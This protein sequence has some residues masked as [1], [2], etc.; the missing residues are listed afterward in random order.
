MFKNI[1]AIS[2][3]LFTFANLCWAKPTL[4]VVDV[5]TAKE[6][7]SFKID[8]LESGL[9]EN[10]FQETKCT[11][12]S[13]ERI[14]FDFENKV[15][16][17]VPESRGKVYKYEMKKD[18]VRTVFASTYPF[19]DRG[20]FEQ[21][22]WID[23][24]SGHLRIALL[25][26]LEV[27][28]GKVHT[29]WVQKYFPTAFKTWQKKYP[30]GKG[31]PAVAVVAELEADGKWKEIIAKQ[32]TIA[33]ETSDGFSVVKEEMNERP[34]TF[35]IQNYLRSLTCEDSQCSDL[36]RKPKLS[37][38]ASSWAKET[39]KEDTMMSI[40]PYNYFPLSGADG[41]LA[42][43]EFGD[44]S[45]WVSPIFYCKGQAGNICEIHEATAKS[46]QSTILISAQS[47]YLLVSAEYESTSALLFK[48]GS[49]VPIKKFSP[50]S[51][52]MWLP[53]WP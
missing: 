11:S 30:G 35:S 41:I 26:N 20:P 39:F 47:P 13:T 45:H 12:P 43:V 15:A 53:E 16:F 21:K 22:D 27:N 42:G 5:D 29:E 51:M 3:A 2:F 31:D 24:K 48:S 46:E 17:A 9:T 6:I 7:C 34:H 52:V 40:T 1:F 10:W 33:E 37:A 44:S 4:L 50:N 49:A 32:T 25:F 38:K 18:A 28:K 23:Q 19:P 36:K 8:H 14:I